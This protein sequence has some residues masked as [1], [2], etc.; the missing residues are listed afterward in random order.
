MESNLGFFNALPQ[1]L[2]MSQ[3]LSQNIVHLVFSTKHRE[4]LLF[5]GLRPELFAV[6]ANLVN[7]TKSHAY[8]V[9]GLDDHVHLALRLHPTLAGSQLVNVLKSQSSQWIK[10]QTGSS[11]DFA[12]QGGYGLF[13]V[14]KTH[15]PG[16]L[17]YIDQQESHHHTLSFQ[18]EF[19]E[20]CR[21][22][23]I[24]FDERYVWD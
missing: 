2:P 3:S 5:R 7:Q 22:N 6:M 13:S 23:G 21:K 14:S 12:W 8:R 16:L 19:R 11:P 24:E 9:G 10:K 1:T 15:L 4:N 18:D 17:D 20:L